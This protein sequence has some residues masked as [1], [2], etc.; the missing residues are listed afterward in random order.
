MYGELERR[1]AA[2]YFKIPFRYWSKQQV[3]ISIR[4][5]L[6]DIRIVRDKSIFAVVTC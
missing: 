1:E 6:G 5:F 2:T 3:S 4:G